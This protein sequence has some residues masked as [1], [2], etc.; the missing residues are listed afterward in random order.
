MNDFLTP[1]GW[2]KLEANLSKPLDDNSKM[3]ILTFITIN[4]AFRVLAVRES[5]LKTP[6]PKLKKELIQFKD[7]AKK[8]IITPYKNATIEE[9]AE[10]EDLLIHARAF[11]KR[12][13]NSLSYTAKS[14]IDSSIKHL[15]GSEPDKY[16]SPKDYYYA[17]LRVLD[18]IK[19]PVLGRRS[20][21]KSAIYNSIFTLWELLG[22]TNLSATYNPTQNTKPE[23]PLV[24]FTHELFKILNTFTKGSTPAL[25]TIRQDIPKYLRKYKPS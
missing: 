23:S 10:E 4:N 18:G 2:Q 3:L 11:V 21:N 6:Q 17:A 5:A 22:E 8:W 12:Q 15:T 20:K 16:P 25:N 24:G 14:E 9:K 19:P 1:L 7:F 13:Y